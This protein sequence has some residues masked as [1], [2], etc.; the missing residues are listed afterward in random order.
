MNKMEP[1][2]HV[3]AVN[4]LTGQ[5]E[6]IT[7]SCSKETAEKILLKMKRLPGYKRTYKR[8]KVEMCQPHQLRFNF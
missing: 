3:T 8:P 7:P 4:P 6:A 1:H 2:Y 5:R